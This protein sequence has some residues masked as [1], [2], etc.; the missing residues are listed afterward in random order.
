VPCL[1]QARS[2]NALLHEPSER[3]ADAQKHDDP[4][5]RHD[6]S[7]RQTARSHQDVEE[8]NVDDDRSEQS[9]RE[10]DVAI[11]QEQDCRDD[12]EQK[13][14]DQI[15]GGKE[16][17]GELTGDSGRWRAGN[18]VEEAIQS[19]DEKDQAKK[20]TGDD[21]SDFMLEVYFSCKVY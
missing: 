2:C 17:A 21:N 1:S 6:D 4:K 7:Q 12:L 13:Y 19:E 15:V 9:E 20:E 8:Q 18:E 16:R 14:D 10:W 5:H 3:G 11:E